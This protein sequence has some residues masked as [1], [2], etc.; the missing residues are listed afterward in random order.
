MTKKKPKPQSGTIALNRKAKHDYFL[1]DKFEAGVVLMG[2]EIKSLRAGRINLTDTYVLLQNGEAW[3]IGTNISPLPTAST[4]FVTEPARTPKLLLN[5]RELDKLEAG[6]NQKGYTCA[7]T[8]LYWKNHLVK[9]E[10]ALA[11]G[12]ATFDKRHEEK[13]RDCD[14]QKKR[15]MRHSA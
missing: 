15:I 13:E 10:I 9:C 1:E 2:W 7:C 8:A 11:K 5:R 4:H 12:K 14:R 3:L 6:L